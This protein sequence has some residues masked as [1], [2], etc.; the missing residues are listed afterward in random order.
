MKMQFNSSKLKALVVSVALG[1]LA[2]SSM[3]S[4]ETLIKF[5]HDLPERD[6]L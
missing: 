4:A 6:A 3:A 2:L 5:H 1:S